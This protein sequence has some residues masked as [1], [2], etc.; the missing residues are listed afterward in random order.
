MDPRLLICALFAL[1]PLMMFFGFTKRGARGPARYEALFDRLQDFADASG[2][3]MEQASPLGS[4]RA[5]VSCTV[6]GFACK[7]RLGWSHSDFELSL[8]VRAPGLSEDDFEERWGRRW[9]RYERRNYDD[10]ITVS[11][12]SS[13]VT[14]SGPGHSLRDTFAEAGLEE[15][16]FLFDA[17]TTGRGE[18][19]RRL[20]HGDELI[21]LTTV[22]PTLTALEPLQGKLEALVRLAQESIRPSDP[23]RQRTGSERRARLAS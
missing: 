7:V 6:S 22:S 11:G 5:E 8:E 18:S 19:W 14:L 16:A 17:P 15:M 21:R 20:S 13:A 12:I 1:G 2:A 10:R 23:P 9:V 3:D 4:L